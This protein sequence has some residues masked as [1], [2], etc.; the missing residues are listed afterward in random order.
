MYNSDEVRREKQKAF[1]I[2]DHPNYRKKLITLS[3]GP[4]YKT[5]WEINKQTL[6]TRNSQCT[7][8][9]QIKKINKWLMK[10]ENL[11]SSVIFFN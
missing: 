7:E 4:P 9:A 8:N 1:G 3:Y 5:I 2:T 10:F 6:I 11:F